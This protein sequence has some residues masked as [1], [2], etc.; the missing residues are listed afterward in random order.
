M[1][2]F[3]LDI[4]IILLIVSIVSVLSGDLDGEMIED[5]LIAFEDQIESGV[6][7]EPSKEVYLLQIEE[8]R[9]GKLG[10][11]LSVF[12]VK[13]VHES[14]GILKDFFEVF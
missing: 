9:A 12:V 5:R 2:R 11:A 14:M 13:V 1:K 8:N 6:V 4:L 10:N 7:Y 3:V